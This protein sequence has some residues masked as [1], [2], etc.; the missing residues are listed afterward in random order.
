MING[1]DISGL[2]FWPMFQG[3]SQQNMAKPVVEYLHFR[4]RV[5]T[6]MTRMLISGVSVRVCLTLSRLQRSLKHS[7]AHRSPWI[8]MDVSPIRRVI[9]VKCS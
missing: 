5:P 9:V 4:I 2:V 7:G 8:S 6:E 1:H 3:T